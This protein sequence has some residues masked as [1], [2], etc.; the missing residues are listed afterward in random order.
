MTHSFFYYIYVYLD[1]IYGYAKSLIVKHV[2]K[3]ELRLVDYASVWMKV[4]IW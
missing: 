2:D 4:Y 3:H 1:M